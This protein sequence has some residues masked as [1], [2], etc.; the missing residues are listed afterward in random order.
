[1]AWDTA[2]IVDHVAIAAADPLGLVDDP[3]FEPR[4]R[5]PH[6]QPT[7]IPA[8][9]AELITELRRDLTRQGLDAGAHTI[10]WHLTQQHQQT[11]S[12]ATIWRTLQRRRVDHPGA[13]EAESGL[14]LLRC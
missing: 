7:A 12:E 10:A 9:T 2:L 1:V 5:R 11:V 13:E 6:S 14:H 4:S 3:A 8:A